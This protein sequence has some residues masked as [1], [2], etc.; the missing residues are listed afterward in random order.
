MTDELKK[1]LNDNKKL[2]EDEDYQLLQDACPGEHRKELRLFLLD[3]A[4]KDTSIIYQSSL[5]QTLQENVD[6]YDDGIFV[7]HLVIHK[8][9]KYKGD[10]FVGDFAYTILMDNKIVDDVFSYDVIANSFP[11]ASSI[12]EQAAEKF[13]AHVRSN[14]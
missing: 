1:F 5:A 12:L 7:I 9:V 14:T 10:R 6:K 3:C 8:P 11:R 4:D 2:I 13:V